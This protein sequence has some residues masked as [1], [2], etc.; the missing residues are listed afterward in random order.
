MRHSFPQK[1]PSWTSSRHVLNTCIASAIIFNTGC[2]PAAYCASQADKNDV[3]PLA[4]DQKVL[5]A[6]NRLTFGPRPGDIDR[7]TTMGVQAF[8]NEQLNPNTLPEADSVKEVAAANETARESNEDLL[9]IFRSVQSERDAR[10]ARR[11]REE[12]AA[13]K[14]QTKTA[15]GGQAKPAAD[16]MPAASMGQAQ[17]MMAGPDQASPKTQSMIDYYN[18]AT[19]QFLLAKLTRDSESPRQ[20]EALMVDFWF[21]HFNVFT[22]KEYDGILIGSYENDAIKPHALGKFKDLV[23]ATCYHPAML[24]YLDN[25]QNKAA[26]SVNENY[27]RELMELHTLGVDGGYSQR[28]V[29]ELARVLTG[30]TIAT[31][32]RTGGLA[33]V[34][35]LKQIGNEGAY[36]NIKQ[37]DMGNKVLLGHVIEGTGAQEID[38]ALDILTRHPA[39]AHH[40]CYQLA[41]YFISDQPPATL[42]NKLAER[43]T[44]TDGNIRSVL[45]DLFAS[46]E[47]WQ[48][49]YTNNKFKTPLRYA[50]SSVRAVDGHIK[51]TDRIANF[52]TQQGQRI[53]GCL[54]PDGYKNTKEQW[55]DPDALLHRIEFAMTVGAG[56]L[57]GVEI[58]T[59]DS[60][61]LE[62]TLGE[63]NFSANTVAVV[64][65]AP[66]NLKAAAVLGSPE[67]MRY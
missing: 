67:F 53:Y 27:A 56:K 63:S 22:D 49:R 21:N 58:K 25:S 55:L 47:F 26:G 13:A 30:L 2:C 11:A 33:Q 36:F 20:L 5:H 10:S 6:I 40:I 62:K 39:T 9:R 17:S 46:E 37:H 65:K 19:R 52:L 41:Q 15:A 16:S 32:M 1:P 3:V 66:K 57:P 8:I 42:V 24:W 43:F 38:E 60:K 34:S 59:P 23:R 51:K 12:E 29:I 14:G 48:A 18:R 54:T 7:V 31:H 50:V 44:S 45:K 4:E 61:A 28:D 64:E 35:G